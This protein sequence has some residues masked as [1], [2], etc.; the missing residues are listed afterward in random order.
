MHTLQAGQILDALKAVFGE[1]NMMAYLAMM[2]VRIVELRRVLKPTGSLYLH[3]DPTASHY[4]KMLLDSLF[5]PDSFLNELIWKRTSAHSSAKRFGPVHD[6]ILF[7]SK[8][9]RYV[10]N[11]SYQPYD[12]TYVN[13]FYTHRDADGRVWRRSDLTGAGTRNGE[14]GKQW[15]GLDVTAKGRHWA[16]PPAELDRMDVAG[17]IHWPAKP[18]GMPML[19]RYLEDQPGMPLQD[20]ITD[21]PPMHNLAAERLHYPTQKP[22]ALLERLVG[23]SSNPGDVVLDPFCGCGTAIDAAQRLGRRW[24]GIDVT[25]LAI[26]VIEGRLKKAFGEGIASQYRV[27]GRPEDPSDARALASRDWLEF[28]KWAVFQLGGIPK[29]RA[30]A[31]GGIDGIIRYHR[32]GIEQPNRAVVSVKGGE[33]VGVDAVHK[34][35]SVVAREHAELGILVCLD[36]PTAAMAREADSVGEVVLPRRRVAKIQIVTVDQ[37]FE[38]HPVDLPGTLDPPELG[39]PE[40]QRPA[41]RSRRQAEGQ[42]ELLL[43]ISGLQEDPQPY[44]ARPNR[45]IRQVDIEVMRPIR[46]P[47]SRQ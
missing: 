40:T 28:Q 47:R 3:C 41:R 34:L 20:V 43:P 8:G 5:G 24:I 19:K 30:G 14:T 4:L 38:R 18:G 35:K 21:V 32:V 46:S 13:A 15:R 26:H 11:Q 22:L 7:Y 27:L 6:V 2:A 29:D 25:Y 1:S 10:W 16:Y 39:R 12:D 42:G 45:S 44:R 23:A 37:M 9:P 17:R 31:D 36:R 33:N